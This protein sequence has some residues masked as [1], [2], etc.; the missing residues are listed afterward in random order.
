MNSWMAAMESKQNFRVLS[1]SLV[2]PFSIEMTNKSIV[3]FYVNMISCERFEFWDSNNSDVREMKDSDD[4]PFIITENESLTGFEPA[5]QPFISAIC[6]ID[7]KTPPWRQRQFSLSV[8][9]S[10][11]PKLN[12]FGRLLVIVLYSLFFA[13]R[14]S[15]VSTAVI[16]STWDLIETFGIQSD[17]FLY[18]G[19]KK[20][21]CNIFRH[22][23]RPHLFCVSIELSIIT[24]I[25]RK[26][27]TNN[28]STDAKTIII[29][30]IF[31][32]LHK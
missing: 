6:M 20:K 12:H 26:P 25:N 28:T 30:E 1:N 29:D 11:V 7:C 3:C 23:C 15:F 2:F 5:S 18:S 17:S 9:C 24:R 19:R 8:Q 13:P 4:S 14:I 21:Y 31:S 16:T 10:G 22:I 27:F 32:G